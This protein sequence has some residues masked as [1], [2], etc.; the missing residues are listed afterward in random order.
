MQ[1]RVFERIQ[2]RIKV[3]LF[4]GF[5]YFTG[6]VTNLSENG[7]CIHS[8]VCLPPES[9]FEVIINYK[10]MVIKALVKVSRIVE[11]GGYYDIMG[12][13]LM[14]SHQDYLEFVD[15]LRLVR[16]LPF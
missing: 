16:K 13:E 11:T 7:M 1:E 6:I 12:V 8:S 4:C 14:N 15:G 10:N 3:R 5:M 9:K 2:T